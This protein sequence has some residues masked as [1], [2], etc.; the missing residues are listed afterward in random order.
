MSLNT[1][2]RNLK[3][4]AAFGTHLQRIRIEKGISQEELADRANVA[5]S[6]INKLENGHLNT[7]ICT[8]FDLARALKVSPKVLFDF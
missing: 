6:T 3:K 2:Q 8:V 4:L 1:K 5:F 7:G